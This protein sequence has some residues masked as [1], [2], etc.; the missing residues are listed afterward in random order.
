MDYQ[1]ANRSLTLVEGERD[2]LSSQNS[3]LRIQVGE[4]TR[5]IAELDILVNKAKDSAIEVSV[6]SY[7]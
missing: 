7:F 6:D 5:K 3:A 4:F 2:M 1:T